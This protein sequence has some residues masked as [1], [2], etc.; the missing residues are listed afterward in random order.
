MSAATAFIL[1]YFIVLNLFYL[2]LTAL[3]WREVARHLH[4]E[5]YVDEQDALSSPLTPPVTLI[6]P[7]YNEEAGVVESVRSVLS[8]RYPE[9][10]VVVVNDGSTDT[11]L[12]ELRAAFDLVPV[13]VA[14]RGSIPCAEILATY[15]SRRDPNLVVVDKVNGG[16][17]DALN[18]GANIARY[19]YVCV[20][21]ADTILEENALIRVMKPVFDDPDLV[22]ATGGIVR[23]ANGCRIE[24]GRVTDVALPRGRL[25]TMQVMEY[26]RA[27]LVGR[28]GWSSVASLLIISGAFGVFKRS[29][30]EEVGGWRTDTVGEDMELV[31]RL[32][33]RARERGDRYRIV[34]VAEPVCWTEAPETL[35]LLSSQRR[36]WQRGLA[37]TLWRHRRMIGNPRYGALGIWGMPYFALF[38][39]AG[40]V[41]EFLGYVIVIA[42]TLT[43]VLSLEV[44]ALFALL[45]MGLGIVL[46]VAALALEELG[47]R[48]YPTERSM[49]RL[50]MYAIAENLGYRQLL[51]FWRVRALIDL[52][53]G[54]RH[55]GE[56]HRRGLGGI[57][58]RKA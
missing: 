13:R 55:W 50:F 45:S 29:S 2:A 17:A 1:G 52:A 36:R 8:L 53:R 20:I 30:I 14:P 54:E 44:F 41:I 39:L 22:I 56:M 49:A 21:D 7:A 5:A 40:P 46:S 32:H 3:A 10:E 34:F 57:A 12:E 19:A 47:F 28:I 11:T 58:S 16:K 25:A 15:R 23:I 43:G 35:R 37:E 31:C 4:A 24:H 9:Y 18:C 42:A 33:R 48:R 27:F 38:E 6:L 51:A 26:L